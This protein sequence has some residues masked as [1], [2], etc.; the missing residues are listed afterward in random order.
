MS[1]FETNRWDWIYKIGG[2]KKMLCDPTIFDHHTL[3]SDDNEFMTMDHI[4]DVCVCVNK[5]IC[6]TIAQCLS[7]TV[8]RSKK[9][10]DLLENLQRKSCSKN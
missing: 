6:L 5:S 4:Y 2:H 9:A 1:W 7:S 3:M 8:V 10:E